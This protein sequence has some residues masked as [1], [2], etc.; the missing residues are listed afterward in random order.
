MDFLEC[1]GQQKQKIFEK[2]LQNK[3]SEN[4]NSYVEKRFEAFGIGRHNITK[5]TYL[6]QVIK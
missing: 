3:S 4:L 6:N 1:R 5:K 2:V